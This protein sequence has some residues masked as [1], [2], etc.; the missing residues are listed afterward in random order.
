MLDLCGCG[1]GRGGVVLNSLS[2]EKSSEHPTWSGR[3]K[4]SKKHEHFIQLFFLS[5][6]LIT[7]QVLGIS[8]MMM[9]T[10]GTTVGGII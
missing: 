6:P 8:A 1:G 5:I 7:L 4:S 3:C 10:S 9:V 2:P